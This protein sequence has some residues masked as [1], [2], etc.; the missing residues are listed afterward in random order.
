MS[1]YQFNLKGQ[2]GNAYYLLATASKWMIQFG[3]K[4]DQIESNLSRMKSGNYNSL[5]STFEDIFE[6][7]PVDFVFLNDPRNPSHWENDTSE[8]GLAVRWFSKNEIQAYVDYDSVYILP[9]KE[10]PEIQ[11]KVCSSEVAYRAELMRAE[12]E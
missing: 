7:Y 3:F 9:I 12:E 10:R 5:L 6:P 4:P 8:Q 2:E 11:I 1:T